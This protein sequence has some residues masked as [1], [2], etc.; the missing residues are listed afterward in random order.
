MADTT[1]ST[2]VVP[3]VYADMLQA[4]FP[5]KMVVG[6]LAVQSDALE[7]QAGETIYFPR[8]LPLMEAEDLTETTNMTPEALTTDNTSSATI[9]E[10]GKAVEIT[11]KALLTA[12]GNPLEE[13]RR[14][15]SLLAARR[16]DFD[17]IK[18]A[19][20]NAAHSLDITGETTK[21]ITSDTI[22]DALA[23]FEDAIHDLAGLVIHSKQQADLFKTSAFRDASQFGDA[24]VIRHG[25]LG[26]VFNIPVY[27]SDRIATNRTVLAASCDGDDTTLYVRSTL[28]FPTSGKIKI[29]TEEMDYASKTDFSFT[30]VTR[31]A[32]GSSAASHDLGA[33]IVQLDGSYADVTPWY[34]ALLIRNGALGLA[35]KRRPIV[36]VDRD[37]LARSTVITTNVHYAIKLV[38]TDR[39]VKI[40]TQ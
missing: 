1:K 17:L 4:E 29:G 27:V 30:G 22:V 2:Q 34:D 25:Q 37:V 18:E 21:T 16:I 38:N 35:Y 31:A 9:K 36:E 6:Q 12:W 20:A 32:N 3:E 8:F 5:G 33:A 26:T 23:E 28:G 19:D 14:Q 24:S 40:K 11:D 10:V 15:M 13:A 39:V 7:G